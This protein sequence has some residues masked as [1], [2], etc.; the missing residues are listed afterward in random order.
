MET[1]VRTEAPGDEDG[2]RAVNRA[3]FG[4]EAEA[5]LVDAVREVGATIL[6]LVAVDGGQIVGHVLFT[7]VAIGGGAGVALGP[8]AVHPKWQR[9]GI[10]TALVR[11]GLEHVRALGHGA[12]VVVGDPRY[13]RRFGFASGSRFG[14]RWERPVPDEV[15]MALELRPHALAN[16]GICRYHPAF[17][18]LD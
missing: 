13:Y 18:D 6:S 4:R 15:F 3:A 5:E 8:L 14:V 12:V 7:P 17:A 2:I 11:E 9:Q 16:G 1:I 10:G